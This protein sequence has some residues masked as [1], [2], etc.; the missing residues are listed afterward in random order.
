MKRKLI[1]VILVAMILAP[2]SAYAGSLYL[3]YER[4]TNKITISGSDFAP[5]EQVAILST[6][7]TTP[8]AFNIADG[9]DQVV[10]DAAGDFTCVI[11]T[12]G[13]LLV[14]ETYFVLAGANSLIN[15]TTSAIEPIIKSINI[16]GMS[17]ILQSPVRTTVSISAGEFKIDA[18]YPGA[19]TVTST[20]SSVLK[21]LNSPGNPLDGIWVQGLKT[22]SA[23]LTVRAG[24]QVA[25]ISV[26]VTY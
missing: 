6:F 9:I 24:D 18:E 4:A 13:D 16:G 19:Y 12:A 20:N 15:P 11:P 25:A 7:N 10:A 21:V 22:G 23:I 14:G 1:F 26:T 3:D 17:A 8:G 5:N 2:L